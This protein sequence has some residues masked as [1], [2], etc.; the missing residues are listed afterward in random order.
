MVEERSIAKIRAA[1][2]SFDAIQKEALRRKMERAQSRKQEQLENYS[3][4]MQ[5]LVRA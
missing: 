5:M 4:Q 1:T 3:K 2:I